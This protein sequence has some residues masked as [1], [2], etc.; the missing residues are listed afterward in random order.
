MPLDSD[1][2][3]EVP[4]GLDPAQTELDADLDKLATMLLDGDSGYATELKTAS[5]KHDIALGRLEK[6]VVP[7][8]RKIEERWKAEKAA[9]DAADRAARIFIAE[10]NA[11]ARAGASSYTLPLG[12][13]M[14]NDG[15]YYTDPAAEFPKPLFICGKFDVLGMVRDEASEGWSVLVQWQDAD[16]ISHKVPILNSLVHKQGNEIAIEF[17]NRGLKCGADMVQHA[18]LKVCLN[19]IVCGRRLQSVQRTGWHHTDNGP[20]FILPGGDAF[21]PGSDGLI[22]SQ[23]DA[24]TEAVYRAGGTLEGWQSSVGQWCIGNSRMVLFVS[25]AFAGPLLDFTKERSGGLNLTGASQSGKTTCSE[26]SASVYG[27]PSRMVRQWRATANGLEGVASH[28]TDTLLVMDDIGQAEAR[29]VGDVVYMIANEGGKSRA[30]RLGAARNTASWRVMMLSTGELTLEARMGEGGKVTTAGQKV[31]LAD[32]PADAGAGYGAFENIHGMKGGAEF[33]RAVREAANEHYGHACRA[34]FDRLTLDLANE[35]SALTIKKFISDIR[36]QFRAM[37]GKDATD[38]QIVSVVGR[39]SLVAAAG[40]LAAHYGV[41]PWPEREAFNGVGKCC[42]AWLDQ[43]GSRTERMEDVTAISQVRAFIEK[44]G[45]SRFMPIDENNRMTSQV[46]IRDQAGYRKVVRGFPDDMVEYW[47]TSEMWTKEV[48]KGLDSKSVTKLLIERGLMKKAKDGK[49]S[50][51]QRIP[52]AGPTRVY[53]VM[54]TIL[55]LD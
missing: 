14:A 17:A 25:A 22:L 38:G 34:F 13:E 47:I 42:K 7:R 31:R 27:K 20:A 2:R 53:V 33:S 21:G 15:L 45:T 41:V 28:S 32:I 35:E 3:E 30:N 11:A 19:G 23:S 49:S 44:H 36:D 43:R 46:P 5:A 16:G 37:F 18:H 10:A 4:P 8:K 40:E 52:D 51:L 50:Y 55:S 1:P 12:Y 9:K 54:G 26:S 29:E 48:C 24:A 6:L 39:F